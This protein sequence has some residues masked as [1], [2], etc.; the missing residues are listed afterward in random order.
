M[1]STLLLD[2]S[3]WDLLVDANGHIALAEDPYATAQSVA[4]AIRLWL[5]EEWYDTTLGVDW[6]DILGVVARPS[7]IKTQMIKAAMSVP[8][9]VSALCFLS[10]L[11]HRAVSGQV[12]V[13]TSAG[14]TI[15][16]AF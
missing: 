14:T 10:S 2:T 12:I 4:T 15:P 3:T 6:F 13:T 9:V 16:I 8:G 1:A 11:S 5:G 7:F